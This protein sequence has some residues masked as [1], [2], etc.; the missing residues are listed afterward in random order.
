MSESRK[1]DVLEAARS[2]LEAAMSHLAQEVATARAA[3]ITAEKMRAEKATLESRVGALEQENLKL[4]EQVATLS[5]QDNGA[6]TDA[7]MATLAE[8]KAAIEQNYGLLKRQYATL[9]DE[10]E[11]LEDRLAAQAAASSDGGD[12]DSA[13]AAENAELKKAVMALKAERDEIR[14][15]LDGAIGQLETIVGDA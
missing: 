4:H 5:L 7:A 15:E 11:G 1:N 10:M 6:D 14:S 8:E 9:Q 13:M 2:R 3:K 12:A